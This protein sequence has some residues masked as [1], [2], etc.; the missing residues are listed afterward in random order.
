MHKTLTVILSAIFDFF[1]L[2]YAESYYCA[3]T[4]VITLQII[5]KYNAFTTLSTSQWIK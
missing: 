1:R 5:T 2:K 3:L 4:D